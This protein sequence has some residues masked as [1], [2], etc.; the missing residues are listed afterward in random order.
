MHTMDFIG[1]HTTTMHASRTSTRRFGVCCGGPRFKAKLNAR[2][3]NFQDAPRPK[4]STDT[5]GTS[6]FLLIHRSVAGVRL[7][8]NG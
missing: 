6:T 8:S 7:D 2:R 1:T 4:R 3:R 5:A